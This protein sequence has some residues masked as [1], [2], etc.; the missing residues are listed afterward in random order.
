MYLDDTDYFLSVYILDNI[1]FSVDK[2]GPPQNLKVT[3]VTDR[4]VSLKWAEPEVDGGCD[5][6]GYVIEERECSKRVWQRI[7]TTD[8][9]DKKVKTL[10]KYINLVLTD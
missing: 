1:L 9:N 5:V 6:T 4:T 7:G 10:L 2:P 3:E 8:A